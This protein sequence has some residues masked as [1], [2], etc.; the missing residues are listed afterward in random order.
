MTASPIVQLPPTTW[1]ADSSVSMHITNEEHGL[2]K[3]R[4]VNKPI[5]IGNGKIVR[6][7]IVG[8]LDVSVEQA[9]R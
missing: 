4:H 8:K 1:I 2:Y 3:K 5:C 9:G 7:T 6:A